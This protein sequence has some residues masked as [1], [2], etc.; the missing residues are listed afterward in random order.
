M[1]EK[2]FETKIFAVYFGLYR[3]FKMESS[4]EEKHKRKTIDL[5]ELYNV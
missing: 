1:C 2:N 5:K 3:N 4:I